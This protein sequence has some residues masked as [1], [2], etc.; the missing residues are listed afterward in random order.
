MPYAHPSGFPPRASDCASTDEGQA[1]ALRWGG[2]VFYRSAGACPPRCPSLS[3]SVLGLTDLR[4]V[5]YR[6]AGALGG[7]HTRIRAG[8]PRE[9]W[10]A[11]ART[12]AWEICSPARVETSEGPR[13]TMKGD[14]LPPRPRDCI[15][16]RRSLLPGVFYPIQLKSV[17]IVLILR[18]MPTGVNLIPTHPIKMRQ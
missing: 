13:L 5:F 1:L 6:S 11:R 17:P 2:G 15:E 4:S 8:F 9:R 3:G 16:T 12:L 14:L 7:F 10:I 18:G